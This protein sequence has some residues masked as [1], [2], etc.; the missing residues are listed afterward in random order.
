MA[1][2]KSSKSTS[3]SKRKSPRKSKKKSRGGILIGLLGIIVILGIIISYYYQKENPADY[4]VQEKETQGQNSQLGENKTKR[5]QKELE[6]KY[7]EVRVEEKNEAKEVNP[8]LPDYDDVDEYYFTHSFDFAWPAY[9]VN[10][11]IVEHEGFTL[12]YDERNEQ[13]SWVAYKIEKTNLDNA[14]F[15]RKDNFRAD[16]LVRTGSATPADYRKSGYDRGHLAPAADFTWSETALDHTFFMSNMSPQVPA[17][18]RGIWKKLEE[19][20]RDWTRENGV[21]YVVTGPI[22]ENKKQRIGSNKVTVPQYYYK[23]ILDIQEPELKAIGFVLDNKKSDAELFSFA[24]TI[25]RLEEITGLDFFPSIPDD[26]E[27]KLEASIKV[28][29][30]K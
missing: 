28:D 13:A 21:I 19:Q 25:D 14:R 27:N 10:D 30:W 7:E 4:V 8:K 18:N 20:V 11:L 17:F 23:A 2:K 29:S 6:N 3:S 5:A 9:D 15:K 12:N 1:K 24:V 26:T 22:V 16:P